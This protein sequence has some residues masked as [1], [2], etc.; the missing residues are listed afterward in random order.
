MAYNN[1]GLFESC[2]CLLCLIILIFFLRISVAMAILL[3]CL[4]SSLYFCLNLGY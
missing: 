1:F 2:L 3:C 4:L